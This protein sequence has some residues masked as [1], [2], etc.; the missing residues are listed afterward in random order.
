MTELD[1]VLAVLRGRPVPDTLERIEAP[2]MSGLADLCERQT[3]LRSLSLA[4]V[5]AGMVG[6]WAGVG[7]QGTSAHAAESLLGVPAAAPSSL[8]VD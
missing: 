2:V 7:A 4:C 6:L 1:T 3:S 5:V 8:L